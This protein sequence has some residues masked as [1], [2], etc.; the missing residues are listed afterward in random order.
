MKTKSF[1]WKWV[2]GELQQRL[3]NKQTAEQLTPPAV[4]PTVARDVESDKTKM[5]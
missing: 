4:F 5:I 1:D 3:A 2:G